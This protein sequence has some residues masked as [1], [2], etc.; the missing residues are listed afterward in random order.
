VLPLHFKGGDGWESLGLTGNQTIDSLLA[1]DI[2]PQGGAR[3]N[4]SRADGSRQEVPLVR[5]IDTAIEVDY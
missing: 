5:R 2:K 1:E 4:I 3:T